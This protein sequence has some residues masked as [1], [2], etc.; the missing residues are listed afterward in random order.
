MFVTA[1]LIIAP[2]WNQPKCPILGKQINKFWYIHEIE[3]YSAIKIS[4]L[5]S[6]KK[7]K[8]KWILV[9]ERSQLEKAI[10]Y[11]IA[12]I[13]HSGKVKTIGT[14]KQCLPGVQG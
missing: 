13:R 1:L 3:Y 5:S 10:Y 6:H 4:E 9:S 12:V 14:I 8:L 11:M 7:K 2:N